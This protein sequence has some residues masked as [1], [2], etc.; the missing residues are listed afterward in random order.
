MS[1]L[2]DGQFMGDMIKAMQDGELKHGPMDFLERES[3]DPNIGKVF[4]HLTAFISGEY[5]DPDSGI[6]HLSR[7]AAN[8]MILDILYRNGVRFSK[9]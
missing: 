1:K 9:K 8:L 2:L 3:F 5:I 7:A 6:S 4:R